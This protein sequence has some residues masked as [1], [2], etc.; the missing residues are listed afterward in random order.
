MVMGQMDRPLPP[1]FWPIPAVSAALASCDLAVLLEEVR[2]GRGWTQKQLALAV[3]YSQSWVS[4]VLGGRQAL[5]VDQV[6]VERARRF[7]REYSGPATGRVRE[8]DDRLGV[9]SGV[10]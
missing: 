10:K 7:R 3:G 2:R 8:F 9:A 1:E 4:N 5:T 6:L